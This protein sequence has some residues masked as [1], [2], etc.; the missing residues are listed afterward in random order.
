[1]KNKLLAMLLVAASSAF[2]QVSIGVGIGG[3]AYYP[4]ADAYGA[5]PYC[6]PSSVWIGGYT[7]YNGYWVD[8]YCAVP[9]YSGA[10]WIG[11]GYFGG[12]WVGGYW[13]GS[14]GYGGYGFRGGYRDYDRVRGGYRDDFRFRQP[15]RLAQRP[16]HRL[17]CGHHETHPVIE[18]IVKVGDERAG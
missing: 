7:D 8:G 2:A 9:P 1:M 4:P 3:P 14:S 18:G 13:G 12:R 6:G 17:Q 15:G 5:P 11:P 16:D 10:Y